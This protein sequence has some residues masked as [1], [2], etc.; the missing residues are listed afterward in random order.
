MN[1]KLAVLDKAKVCRLA[2][3]DGKQPYIVPLNFGYTYREGVLRLYFHSAREGKKIDIIREN[4]KACFE[5]EGGQELIQGES[6]CSHGF[7]FESV[8]AFGEIRFVESREEKIE[9][10]NAIMLRQTGKPGPWE[11]TE[12]ALARTAVYQLEA[13][14][15]TGK[16]RPPVRKS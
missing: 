2:L 13:G 12:E 14:S 4:P 8:I 9:A 1:E 11:Y 16:C 10:L 3:C 6:A 15:F 7:A 5:A